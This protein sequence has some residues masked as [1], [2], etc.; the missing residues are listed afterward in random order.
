MI[1]YL[2]HPI[3]P[4]F[5]WHTV[6][7]TYWAARKFIKSSPLS[8]A[9]LGWVPTYKTVPYCESD[10]E[11]IATGMV[12]KPEFLKYSEQTSF[13]NFNWSQKGPYDLCRITEEYR[14]T[15]N[16][17]I[18]ASIG[19][20]LALLQGIH[21][22]VFGRPLFWG[23]FGAKLITPFGLAGKLATR[24]FRERLQQQY[25]RRAEPQDSTKTTQES[26]TEESGSRVEI[27][28][29][30]FLLDYV[31]DMGPASLPSPPQEKQNSETDSSDSEDEV[32]Y[33]RVRGLGKEDG[34]EATKLE[35]ESGTIEPAKS[36]N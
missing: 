5:R 27:D 25:H 21:V 24:A 30:R 29:T 15:S 28:M 17:D 19:G 11:V 2:T 4:E 1:P 31:I 33:E 8:D 18:L 23:M 12:Y 10:V 7:K 32:N 6:S 22:L 14:T 13:A 26:G 20:L 34:V 35:W 36:E 16:F 9:I 3:F